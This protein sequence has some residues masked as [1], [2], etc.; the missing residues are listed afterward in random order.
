MARRIIDAGYPT[1]LYARRV[2]TL[3]PFANSAAIA[4]SPAELAAASDMVCV[5]VVDDAGVEDVL[6]AENGVLAGLQ[7]GGIVAIHSTINP[8]SCRRLARLVAQQGGALV[9]APVSGGAGAAAEGRLLVMVGGDAG[10]V[11]RCSPVFETFAGHIAHLGVVGAGQI[12]KLINNL[13]FTAQL[14]TASG[15]LELAGNFGIDPGSLAGVLAHGSAASFALGLTGSLGGS[16]R[17]MTRRGAELLQ[18]DV[19]LVVDLAGGPQ[20]V[21][22]GLLGPA[23]QALELMGRPR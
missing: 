3:E 19:R 6:M 4:A 5:C 15:A 9:D 10:S 17:G 12:T 18:K 8:D 14:A 21:A 13:L 20:A 11:K 23:D 22:A 1:T 7:P 16:A 2:A